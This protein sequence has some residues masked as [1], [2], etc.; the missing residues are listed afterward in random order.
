MLFRRLRLP[1]QQG[2]GRQEQA[3]LLHLVRRFR[4]YLGTAI[5]SC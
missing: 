2:R 3:L 5:C 4:T 1:L